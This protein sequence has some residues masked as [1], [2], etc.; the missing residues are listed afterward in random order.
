MLRCSVIGAVVVSTLVMMLIARDCH[1]Y[2][3]CLNDTMSC[4][5]SSTVVCYGF[6][7]CTDAA[8]CVKNG[9]IQCDGSYSCNV[10]RGITR[11]PSTA[12]SH[13]YCRGLSSCSDSGYIYHNIG[14][15][16]CYGEQS[17]TNTKIIL[18]RFSSCCQLECGGDQS[19]ANS[20]IISQYQN[21]FYSNLAAFN[22]TRQI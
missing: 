16:Y 12:I 17:C 5:S 11:L 18:F 19:C 15:L 7:S 10:A 6:R 1:E 13:V 22:S 20:E 4:S 8:V 9:A 2:E 14:D 3:S 21:M